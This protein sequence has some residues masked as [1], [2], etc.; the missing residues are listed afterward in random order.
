MSNLQ[1]IYQEACGSFIGGASA[2]GRYNTTLGQ[3]L[4]L[5]SADGSRIVDA[6]KNI[7]I[8]TQALGLRFLDIII[9]G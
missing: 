9:Q 4:Y 8:T 2:G 6:E 1:E 7:S 5:R 3:P